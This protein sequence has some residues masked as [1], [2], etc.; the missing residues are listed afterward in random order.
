MINRR[1]IIFILLAYPVYNAVSF[2]W[3]FSLNCE[4]NKNIWNWFHIFKDL[5]E[6]S[7]H[8]A[9]KISNSSFLSSKKS[10]SEILERPKS[11]DDM[12]I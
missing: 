7:W 10:N 5:F 3:G 1:L 9:V 11:I 8:K 2:V 4:K 6:K 12:K